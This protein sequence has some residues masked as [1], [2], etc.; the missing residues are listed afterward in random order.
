[1]NTVPASRFVPRRM[2]VRL[3]LPGT[4]NAIHC[5]T[6][7]ISH[8]HV[9]IQ[10]GPKIRH[11]SEVQL[12]FNRPD[13]QP[14]AVNCVVMPH[15]GERLLLCYGELADAERA[16]LKKAI[17]PEWDGR[18][19]LKGL[20]LMA[21]RCE[22]QTLAEWLRLTSLLCLMQQRGAVGASNSPLSPAQRRAVAQV[23]ARRQGPPG[24]AA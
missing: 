22:E 3:R 7:E 17:W 19:L 16:L 23:G 12:E 6:Q 10:G 5:T 9:F 2:K 4:D 13:G 1:M 24:Q 15:T 21:D 8:D 14:V 20:I 11:G 18:D